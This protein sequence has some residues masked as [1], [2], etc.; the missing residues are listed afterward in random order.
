MS[1]FPDQLIEVVR[2]GRVD[3]RR[4]DSIVESGAAHRGEVALPVIGAGTDTNIEIASLKAIL[5][6]LN[7]RVGTA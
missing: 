4:R 7:R 1:A 3:D 6:A 2:V 5:S